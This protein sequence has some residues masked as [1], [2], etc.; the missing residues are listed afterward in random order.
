MSAGGEVGRGNGNQY[1]RVAGFI[2]GGRNVL[3]LDNGDS[4]TTSGP[5]YTPLNCSLAKVKCGTWISPL[6]K[7]TACGST[8]CKQ[9]K[10]QITQEDLSPRS[11]LLVRAREGDG[12]VGFPVMFSPTFA[13]VIILLVFHNKTQQTQHY[14]E[15]LTAE[16]F[17]NCFCINFQAYFSLSSF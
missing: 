8:N 4:C 9:E 13:F 16:T 12:R 5:H 17:A 3:K 11:S 7:R 15:F 2:L 6:Q 14:Q 1:S 10:S